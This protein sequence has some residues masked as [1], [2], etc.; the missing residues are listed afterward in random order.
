MKWVVHL[1]L[2]LVLISIAQA[3]TIQGEVYDFYLNKV[4]QGKATISTEPIQQQ[5]ITDGTYSFEVEA[6]EYEL[7]AYQLDD[8]KI[9]SAT[10]ETLHVS[11]DGTYNID[12]ILFPY[13]ESQNILQESEILFQEPEQI[14]LWPF[15]V[16]LI[17]SLI[18]MAGLMILAYF[19]LKNLK[20]IILPK[21]EKKLDQELQKVLDYIKKHKRATQKEIRK[22]FPLSEGKISLMISE[23]EEK[24]LVKKIKKGRGNIVVFK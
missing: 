4:T 5:V 18:V 10:K 23:L 16:A 21:E 22:E 17:G 9:I 14:N 19:K 2:I 12:L 8:G 7:I 1:L 3:A 13:F 15:Y 11:K 6:G 20:P 24:G